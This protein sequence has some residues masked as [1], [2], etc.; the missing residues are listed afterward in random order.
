MTK[1]Q[2]LD[3]IG[4]GRTAA[5]QRIAEE[6]ILEIHIEVESLVFSRSLQDGNR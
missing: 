6:T 4:L 5:V 3:V 2:N 1:T